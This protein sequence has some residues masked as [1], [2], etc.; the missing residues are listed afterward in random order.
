MKTIVLATANARYIHTSSGL[1]YLKANLRELAPA[2]EIIEFTIDERPVDMAEAILARN[3][4]IVG[5]GVY[6]WNQDPLEQV[7]RIVRQLRPDLP[8]VLGGPEV[9][10]AA[11]L[12]PIAEYASHIV[13]GEAEAAFYELCAALLSGNAPDQKFIDAALPDLAAIA[14]PYSLYNN[15]DISHRLLYIEASRGCPNSCEFCLSGRDGTVRRFPEAAV[16]GALADLWERGARQFKFVDRALHLGITTAILDFF[17]A[18]LADTVFVHFEAIPGNLPTR[19]FDRLRQFP[20][21]SLQLEVGVQTLNPDVAARIGR[22]KTSDR[23]LVDIR[24][25]K[26]ETAA[27]IHADLV[28]GLP[29]ETLSSFAAGFDAL[30]DAAPDEIQVGILKR[31]R[32]AAISRHDQEWHMHYSASPPYEI[33]QTNDIDFQLMQRLK[34]FSRYFDMVVNSGRFKAA[35]PLIWRDQSPFYAFLNFSDWLFARVNRTSGI[36]L[37][38]LADLLVRYLVE[39]KNLDEAAA[40]AAV[41]PAQK[42]TQSAPKD[43]ATPKRQQRHKG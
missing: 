3:P 22:G 26:A 4:A 28:V 36:A 5:L 20:A 21:G 30:L 19:L 40:I 14:L 34:R 10:C 7:A 25:L 32:G 15:E 16:L 11:D 17:I 23:I 27:H 43:I 42:K 33:L 6:I 8:I 13:A 38:K 9:I 29:G 18:R 12:P 37:A 31:L 41:N 39:E 35:A 1:R 24:R 2:T